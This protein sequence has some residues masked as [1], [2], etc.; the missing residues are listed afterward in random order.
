MLGIPVLDIVE[1]LKVLLSKLSNLLLFLLEQVLVA[2]LHVRHLLLHLLQF[3]LEEGVDVLVPLLL[4][5]HHSFVLLLQVVVVVLQVL[6][7]AQILLDFPFV[8]IELLVQ[9]PQSLFRHQV[10]LEE[11]APVRPII[12]CLLDQL[13]I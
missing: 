12:E 10:L 6:I 4:L 7:V 5:G 11:A 8:P 2:V 9:F 3:V 1:H 13:L